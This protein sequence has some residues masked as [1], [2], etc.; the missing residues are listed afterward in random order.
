[1]STAQIGVLLADTADFAVP[2]RPDRGAE[3]HEHR[4]AIHTRF[5]HDGG[6][7]KALTTGIRNGL[8]TDQIASLTSD[9]PRPSR[10]AGGRHDH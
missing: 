8:T 10:R 2:R 9:Q 7:I 3:H 6:Q 5:R 4:L 1:M